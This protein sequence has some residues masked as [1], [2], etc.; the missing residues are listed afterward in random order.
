MV[1][2]T[3]R[4]IQFD[5]VLLFGDDTC[6]LTSIYPCFA[7]SAQTQDLVRLG[8]RDPRYA[9]RTLAG[10]SFGW[11]RC[12]KPWELGRTADSCSSNPHL[13]LYSHF[14]GR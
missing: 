9:V 1:L 6:D 10:T 14:S 5:D 2:D 13:A 8:L 4:E 3:A 7:V 11:F 12:S